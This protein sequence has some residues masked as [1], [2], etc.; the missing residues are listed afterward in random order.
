MSSKCALFLLVIFT[1]CN[2]FANCITDS[3]TGFVS[4]IKRTHINLYA[5]KF[6]N[7]IILHT[8]SG[9]SCRVILKGSKTQLCENEK[10]VGRVKV[11]FG[12]IVRGI[13]SGGADTGAFVVGQMV[14]QAQ[15]NPDCP[16]T[17]IIERAAS[18]QNV[19][20]EVMTYFEV[21]GSYDLVPNFQRLQNLIYND[22]NRIEQAVN[23][24]SS[25]V[26][27]DFST[28]ESLSAI[29]SPYFPNLTTTTDPTIIDQYCALF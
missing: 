4:N 17:E 27:S 5:H 15:L 6:A 29:Q 7:Q 25:R 16:A 1:F 26:T 9:H 18:L 3:T 8:C 28:D 10:A 22:E 24:F 12:N 20:N 11:A 23:F 2:S 19:N 14:K 13:A 21:A